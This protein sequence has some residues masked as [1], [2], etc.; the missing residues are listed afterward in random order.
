MKKGYIRKTKRTKTTQ[1]HGN[2]VRTIHSV[3]LSHNFSDIEDNVK[4]FEI[5]RN[6]AA[7][8]GTNAAQEARAAGLSRAY[9]RNYQNL[10]K[11]S[12]QGEE[13]ALVP[14]TIRSSFYVKFEPYTVFHAVK[15]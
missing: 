9:V 4:G 3:F 11:V 6:I 13:V 12:P 1:K 2:G 5:I 14:K 7:H 15:K 8:A 10:V